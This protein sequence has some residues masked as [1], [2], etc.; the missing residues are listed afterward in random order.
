MSELGI[1]GA[2]RECGRQRSSN[3]R[4]LLGI[5]TKRPQIDSIAGGLPSVLGT[6][7]ELEIDAFL[8]GDSSTKPRVLQYAPIDGTPELSK[9]FPRFLQQT[10]GIGLALEQCTFTNGAQHGLDILA[11]MF[12][13]EGDV[14]FV[15]VPDYL[16]ALRA[17][18]ARGAE[19]IGIPMDEQG[20]VVDVL[21]EELA[22]HRS[23]AKFVYIVPDF[24]NPS[25]L[26]TSW[27]RKK[28]LLQLCT[29]NQLPLIEDCPYR[30]IRF[31]G[32]MIPSL[33]AMDDQGIVIRLDTTSKIWGVKRLGMISSRNRAV[34]DKADIF[35]GNTCLNIQ[36]KAQLEYARALA[37]GL[38][39][40]NI[41]LAREIYRNRRDAMLEALRRN[42]GSVD[43]VSWTKP[44]GGLF[45]WLTMPAT[46]ASGK[47]VD[48]NEL[49]Q[50]ALDPPYEVVFVPGTDFC[51]DGTGHN[52]MRL[53]YSFPDAPT[54][55][56]AVGKLSRLIKDTL[57]S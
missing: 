20:M 10:E 3:I 49:L 21:V 33:L 50:I 2:S 26:T 35:V 16:G 5:I 34:I 31:E 19:L 44:N 41:A 17:F 56:R 42:L 36:A 11:R 57:A 8:I 9:E 22:K 4:T 30:L 6:E 38:V 1:I 45:L 13:D 37:L 7:A 28:Q 39:E 27:E 54:I 14:C 52:Q 18:E 48:T 43:G 12:L 46:T 25:G 53:N 23:R 32:E 55:E 51:C 47:K 15:C 29:E 40:Q 24:A